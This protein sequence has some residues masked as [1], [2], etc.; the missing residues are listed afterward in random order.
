MRVW[1]RICGPE[2]GNTRG[3][4]LEKHRLESENDRRTHTSA[5]RRVCIARRSESLCAE[6]PVG[7]KINIPMQRLCPPTQKLVRNNYFNAISLRQ[8]KQVRFIPPVYRCPLVFGISS[9]VHNVGK[10]NIQESKDEY[11]P[12]GDYLHQPKSSSRNNTAM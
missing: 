9:R 7:S 1:V 2:S 3:L 12:I 11:H 5:R 6:L 10:G 8:L 4:C